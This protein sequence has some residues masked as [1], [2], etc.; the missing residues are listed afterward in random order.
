M[1]GTE[2]EQKERTDIGIFTTVM[3]AIM[4]TVE[5]LGDGKLSIPGLPYAGIAF[6]TFGN[7]Y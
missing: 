5:A 4:G 7:I 6:D 3:G 2:Q 1:T